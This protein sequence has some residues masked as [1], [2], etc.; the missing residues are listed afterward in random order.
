M[1]ELFRIVRPGGIFVTTMN[2]D[3]LIGKML[4]DELRAYQTTGVAVRDK[5]QQ[6]KTMFAACHL[7]NYLRTGLFKQFEVLEH[8]PASFPFTAQD[9]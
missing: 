3:S 5:V 7:P 4:P 9:C 6:G 2:D 1:A 8:A